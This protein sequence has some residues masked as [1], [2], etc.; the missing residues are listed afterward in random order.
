LYSTQNKVPSYFTNDMFTG[1]RIQLPVAEMNSLAF[2]SERVHKVLGM[3]N[4]SFAD[5]CYSLT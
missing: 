5:C 1:F 2:V 4:P 3:L